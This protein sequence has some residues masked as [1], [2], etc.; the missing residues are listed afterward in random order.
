MDN[1]G[2]KGQGIATGIADPVF[3]SVGT[4]VGVPGAAGNFFT[5]VGDD[6]LAF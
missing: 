4:E 3:F 5:V 6:G 2:D 1:A